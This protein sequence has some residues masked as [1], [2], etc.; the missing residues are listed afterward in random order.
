MAGVKLFHYHVYQQIVLLVLVEFALFASAPYLAALIRFGADLTELD[1]GGAPQ[2]EESAIFAGVLSLTAIA[3]GLYS[4]RLRAGSGG[5]LLRFCI[6]LLATLVVMTIVFYAVPR[7]FLGRGLLALSALIAFVAFVGTRLVANRF[8]GS[9]VFR[10]KVLVYGTGRRVTGLSQLRRRSDQRGFDIVGYVPTLT[11]AAAIS[12]DLWIDA[13]KPLLDLCVELDIDEIVVGIDDRRIE[14]PVEPLLACKLYG[15]A[16]TE[17]I[18]FLEREAGKIRLDALNPAWVIFAPG[19]DRSLL[20][21]VFTRLLDIVFSAILLM[22]GWPIMVLAAAAIM[23]EDGLS[24]P[25][26]Y[27][28]SRVGLNGRQFQILKFRSMRVDAESA[29]DPRWARHEDPRITGVGALL[30]RTRLDELPQLWNVL[31]GD[32]SLIGPRPERPEFVEEFERRIPF[33]QERHIVKPGIT[34]WAQLC[35]PYGSS[36]HDTREK[37]E[38]DLYYI[39][40]RGVVFNLMIL[41]QTV[42]VILLGKGGR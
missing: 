27:R 19:F 25:V 24:K 38:Y 22:L 15:I 12:K 7:L 6:A 14:F 32:M 5:L 2:W 4:R 8:I 31:I 33:Y 1:T 9:Q 13:G 28:Q 21:E 16:V 42:E 39:K 37:L 18:D 23:V 40:N 36:E 41:V 35:Y 10:R 11:D 17:V 26:F 29:G 30:R 3:M 20:T 34:G